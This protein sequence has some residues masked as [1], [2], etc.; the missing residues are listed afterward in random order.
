MSF[1]GAYLLSI[2]VIC[3]GTGLAVRLR[4]GPLPPGAVGTVLRIATLVTVIAC[5]WDNLAV[6][7]GL[8]RYDANSLV[9]IR[10]GL[11]PLETC[12]LGGAVAAVLAMWTIG[13]REEL[14]Q[15]ELQGRNPKDV[16]FH[17]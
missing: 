12:L 4:F 11:A 13:V 1:A 14:V 2:V 5:L 15:A 9:G 17:G 7:G 3:G 6:S 16:D 8:W 10:F